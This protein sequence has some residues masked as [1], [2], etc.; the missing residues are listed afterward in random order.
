MPSNKTER[1]GEVNAI[2]NPLFC[3]ASGVHILSMDEKQANI[4]AQD[5]RLYVGAKPTSESDED[6]LVMLG[7]QFDEEADAWY[8]QCAGFRW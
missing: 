2:E 4:R 7:W 3:I 5:N 8:F 6:M 1:I